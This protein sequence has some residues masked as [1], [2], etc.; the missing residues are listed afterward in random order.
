MSPRAAPTEKHS[1]LDQG[2]KRDTA[3]VPIAMPGTY[4][5]ERRASTM[6]RKNYTGELSEARSLSVIKWKAHDKMTF[7]NQKRVHCNSRYR[8]ALK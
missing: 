1:G 8:A 3:T 2:W 6:Q 7:V 4:D 5:M